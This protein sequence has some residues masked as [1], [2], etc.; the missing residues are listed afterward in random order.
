M[1]NMPPE[2]AISS[3]KVLQ[4]LK[5]FGR[6]VLVCIFGRS[7]GPP[8]LEDLHARAAVDHPALVLVGLLLRV[9]ADLASAGRISLEGVRFD[10]KMLPKTFAK[11]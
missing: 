9:A 5:N 8:D 10:T 4:F 3:P 11:F 1:L 7:S 6:I 2:T